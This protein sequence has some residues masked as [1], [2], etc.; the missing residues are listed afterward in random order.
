MTAETFIIV[1]EAIVCAAVLVWFVAVPWQSVWIAVSRQRI[2]ELR[3][4]LFDMAAD[5]KIE[6]SNPDYIR[7][8]EFLNGCIRF[9][10]KIN[11]EGFLLWALCVD[12]RSKTELT[13]LDDMENILD[14]NV[15]QEIRTV[16]RKAVFSIFGYM[17]IR[18]LIFW[19][20]LFLLPII[21]ILA[22]VNNRVWEMTNAIYSKF[23]ALVLEVEGGNTLQS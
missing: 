15:R 19:I 14:K 10:H 21:V 5:G 17:A 3:D 23:R 22:F 2:F 16:I 6:F 8:R 12:L 20:L 11:F 7:S 1:V 9:S 4:S 13:L 18:S